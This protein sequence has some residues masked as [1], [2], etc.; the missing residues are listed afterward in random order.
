MSRPKGSLN[1]NKTDTNMAVNA[2]INTPTPPL[3][4]ATQTQSNPVDKHYFAS[5]QIYAESM[6][7]KPIARPFTK[8]QIE[9]ALLNPSVSYQTLQQMSN[10]LYSVSSAYINTIDYFA[11]ILS[12]DYLIAPNDYTDN[13]VTMM[14]RLLSAAKK[15]KQSQVKTVFPK[16]IE[17]ALVQGEAYFYTLT[18]NEN[19][20]Y[21]EIPAKFCEVYEIDSNNLFRYKIRL[22]LL[23]NDIVKSL[24][25]EIREAYKTFH[26]NKNKKTQKQDKNDALD[27]LKFKVSENGFAILSHGMLSTH[28]Y[29][30]FS[31][32]FIDLLQLE[33]DKEY[34]NSF[35][36]DD[37]V[38]MVHNLI[39]TND[40]TGEP[41]IPEPV[42]R[43]YHESDKLHV[44][45]NVSVST[46]PFKKEAISFDSSSRTQIN[47]VEQSKENVQDDSGVSSLVFNN[48]KAS[49][50]ALKDAIRADRNRV[51]HFLKFFNAIL[52]YQMKPFKFYAV[53]LET[54]KFTKS[55]THEN[56]RTDLQSGGNRMLFIATS[57][58]EIYDFLQIAQLEKVIEID[59]FLPIMIP[60]SQQ[61][62]I[63][64][65]KNGR[66]TGEKGNISDNGEKSQ[67]YK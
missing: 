31:S 64:D 7:Y 25:L 28:D 60:G 6:N 32:M 16:M 61:S 37:N 12:F 33:E 38:K 59:E 39:P 40:E 19:T 57:E 62:G 30:Y 63:D 55:D 13:K 54:D 2:I 18:D 53:F 52:S 44:P 58:I 5:S 45:K 27:A 10:Y 8:E 56:I 21:V 43:K 14:N 35:I 15:A 9:K 48:E 20:I 4:N 66:P 65:K 34:L 47:L 1:K 17:R 11:N 67:E 24:P 26:E 3:L 49:S 29:P 46:T 51:L 22:D 50:N 41:L 42:I 36:R 23:N